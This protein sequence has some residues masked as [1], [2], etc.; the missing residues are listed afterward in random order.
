M[1]LLEIPAKALSSK[2]MSN[3]PAE[4]LT[5]IQNHG[6]QETVVL[7]ETPGYALGTENSPEE[8]LRRMRGL[9]ERAAKLREMIRALREANAR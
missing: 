6:S 7:D 1:K 5:A 2:V 9:P 3:I 4:D 8:T